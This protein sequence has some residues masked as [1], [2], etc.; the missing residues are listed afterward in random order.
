MFFPYAFPLGNLTILF[1]TGYKEVFTKSMRTPLREFLMNTKQ[2]NRIPR[3]LVYKNVLS[4]ERTDFTH[5][6]TTHQIAI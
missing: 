3:N 4:E 2:Q 1:W 5:Q 6:P